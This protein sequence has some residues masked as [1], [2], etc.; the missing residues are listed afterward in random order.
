[1]TRIECP[2]LFSQI[3]IRGCEELG[4]I[5]PSYAEGVPVKSPRCPLGFASTA[6]CRVSQK[7]FQKYLDSKIAQEKF[8]T[9]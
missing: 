5:L 3:G 4:E 9:I 1:M 6:D 2:F 8:P 7:A